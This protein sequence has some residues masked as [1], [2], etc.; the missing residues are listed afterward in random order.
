MAL[1]L[2]GRGREPMGDVSAKPPLRPGFMSSSIMVIPVWFIMPLP[3]PV[4]ASKSFRNC[5]CSRCCR[6]GCCGGASPRRELKR[7]MRRPRASSCRWSARTLEP[8]SP[9]RAF[10]SSDSVYA[11]TMFALPRRNWRR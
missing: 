5:C 6:L 10:F 9:M 1:G 8:G 2:S 4:A 7:L 3:K 11:S